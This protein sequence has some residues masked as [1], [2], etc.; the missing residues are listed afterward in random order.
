MQCSSRV[1]ISVPGGRVS[2]GN[3]KNVFLQS[4]IVKLEEEKN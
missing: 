1:D 3:C 2:P 4:K